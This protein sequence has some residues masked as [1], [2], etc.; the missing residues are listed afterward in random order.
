MQTMGANPP[1]E[2]A[3][4]M[5]FANNVSATGVKLMQDVHSTILTAT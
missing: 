3:E 5:V 4:E 2:I 1:R